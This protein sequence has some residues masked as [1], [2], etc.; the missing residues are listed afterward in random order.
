[1]TA[2]LK[3]AADVVLAGAALLVLLPLLLSIACMVRLILGAPI[4]FLQLRPGHRARAFR[5]VKFRTMSDCRDGEGRVLP[6]DQRLGRFGRFLRNS[7]LD[8]LPELWNV[9][10]GELSLV[11]PR[12]LLLEYLPRYSERHARRH[13]V[14]PGVTGWAQINGRNALTWEE[15]FELDVWYVDHRGLWLDIKILWLTLPKVLRRAGISRS[16]Y[17]TTP[18]FRGDGISETEEDNHFASDTTRG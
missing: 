13:E 12:P 3:R 10:R 2:N 17:A 5:L 15:K 14:K 9:L 18:Y 1:M 16:G 8:E 7:S 6:D 4:F 11:G